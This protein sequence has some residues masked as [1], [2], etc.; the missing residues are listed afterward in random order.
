MLQALV[1]RKPLV[2]GYSG[3]IPPT[4]KRLAV[5]LDDLPTRR[6]RASLRELGVRYLVVEPEWL[7]ERAQVVTRAAWLHE[8]FRGPQRVIYEVQR[9]R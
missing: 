9:R 6:S 5:A 8:R 4:V 2:D 1:H 7:R 3:F